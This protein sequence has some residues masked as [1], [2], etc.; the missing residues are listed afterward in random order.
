M[1]LPAL[2]YA[3]QRAMDDY[4]AKDMH[5][6]DLSEAALKERFGLTDVSA[7]VNPYTLTLVP[8]APASSY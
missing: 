4:G 5:H 3:T 1:P 6:G 7:K 8:P 2:I